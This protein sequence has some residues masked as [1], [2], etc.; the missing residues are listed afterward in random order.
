MSYAAAADPAAASD[1]DAEADAADDDDAAADPAGGG[2]D[3]PKKR[4]P[5]TI[6][7]DL[8]ARA[9]LLKH[10]Q[11][12]STA[13]I[14]RWH[15]QLASTHASTAGTRHCEPFVFRWHTSVILKLSRKNVIWDM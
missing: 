8:Q 4:A 15:L 5:R 6:A 2:G 7:G 14:Y 11:L 1:A 10:L 12:A 13:G 3:A 9:V